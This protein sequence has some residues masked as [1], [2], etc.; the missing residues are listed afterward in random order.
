MPPV[1]FSHDGKTK[2]R[3][4]SVVTEE[5][6][7]HSVSTQSWNCKHKLTQPRQLAEDQLF[8]KQLLISLRSMD[9]PFQNIIILYSRRQPLGIVKVCHL[10]YR[11]QS[12][13]ILTRHWKKILLLCKWTWDSLRSWPWGVS[14]RTCWWAGLTLVCGRMRTENPVRSRDRAGSCWMAK[15]SS[16]HT[17]AFTSLGTKGNCRVVY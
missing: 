15:L 5:L 8:S 13:Q 10:I 12:W 17:E 7:I 14:L 4:C 11:C 16:P 3:R 6:T 9:A 1:L 2:T